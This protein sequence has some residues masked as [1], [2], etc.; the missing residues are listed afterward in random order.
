M[1][2]AEILL[3]FTY[4]YIINVNS[5]HV[6]YI[7]KPKAILFNMKYSKISVW[8][9]NKDYFFPP[10]KDRSLHRKRIFENVN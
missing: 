9:F 4:I 3:F 6:F 8:H 5:S 7:L 10:Y 1:Y 2:V